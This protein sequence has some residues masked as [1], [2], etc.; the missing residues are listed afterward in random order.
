MEQ[1]LEK[2]CSIYD[3]KIETRYSISYTIKPEF[4]FIVD[5]IDRESIHVIYGDGLPGK[6]FKESSINF[7][8]FPI[9]TLEKEL[10]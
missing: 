4:W 3:V 2:L 10:L 9:S 5:S 6:F 1:K 8:E 7:Y